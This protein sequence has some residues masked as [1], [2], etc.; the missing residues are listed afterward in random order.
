[1]KQSNLRTLALFLLLWGMG[2]HSIAQES[3]SLFL[4]RKGLRL[5]RHQGENSLGMCHE[6][7]TLSNGTGEVFRFTLLDVESDSNSEALELGQM[8][9]RGNRLVMLYELVVG[10]GCARV[11]RRGTQIGVFNCG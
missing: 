6:W 4:A 8:E 1:M 3:D 11:T 7:M 2:H 10:R 9:L 5:E